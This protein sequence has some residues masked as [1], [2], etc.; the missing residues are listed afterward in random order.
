MGTAGRRSWR[1]TV[2][3]VD[4]ALDFSL[5]QKLVVDVPLSLR[6]LHLLLE[7]STTSDLQLYASSLCVC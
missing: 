2:D 4:V 3:R 6:V 7:Q 5:S 1:L